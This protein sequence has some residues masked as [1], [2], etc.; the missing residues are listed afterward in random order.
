MTKKGGIHGNACFVVTSLV[1]LELQRWRLQNAEAQTWPGWEN[2]PLPL[3]WKGASTLKK[4]GTL[5]LQPL[6]RVSRKT[7]ITTL[8][9]ADKVSLFIQSGRD[10]PWMKH[11]GAQ[12]EIQGGREGGDRQGSSL[13]FQLLV[14]VHVSRWHL[15]EAPQ[16]G[17]CRV[18]TPCSSSPTAPPRTNPL[19]L[20]DG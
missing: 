19:P 2:L 5:V 7:F 18:H 20:P 10:K 3:P 4:R 11:C 8:F 17:D 9:C 16:L 13:G 14:C 15:L 6:W 1:S 12:R